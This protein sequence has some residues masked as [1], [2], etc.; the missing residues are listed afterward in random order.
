LRYNVRVIDLSNI[1]AGGSLN[2]D[3]FAESGP[4]IAAIGRGLASE[5]VGKAGVIDAAN[6]LGKSILSIPATIVGQPVE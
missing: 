3:K 4:V 5:D 1:Q 2:H 6:T